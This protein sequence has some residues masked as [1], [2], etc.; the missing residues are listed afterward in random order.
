MLKR[1]KKTWAFYQ[2]L[3]FVCVLSGLSSPNWGFYWSIL[4]WSP[5]AL[6]SSGGCASTAL[7]SLAAL[8]PLAS[9]C[10]LWTFTY[11]YSSQIGTVSRLTYK[12]DGQVWLL[13][14]GC[15]PLHWGVCSL[16]GLSI[17]LLPKKQISQKM[18]LCTVVCKGG[19]TFFQFIR[20]FILIFWGVE[21]IPW[22]IWILNARL[23]RY[24]S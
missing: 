10:S 8:L 20:A 2:C 16:E 12:Q 6:P 22:D 23:N 19:T 7:P 17:W 11:Y 14:D 13:R 3:I 4:W 18:Y 5:F 9:N 15:P 24:C 1:N 21:R